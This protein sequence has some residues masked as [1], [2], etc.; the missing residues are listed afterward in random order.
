MRLLKKEKTY[1]DI[2]YYI[3]S[4]NLD[5]NDIIIYAKKVKYSVY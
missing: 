4:E 5:L 2:I 3:L 1:N